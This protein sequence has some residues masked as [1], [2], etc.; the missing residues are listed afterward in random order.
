MHRQRTD[1]GLEGEIPWRDC[2]SPGGA[3][4]GRI[5]L[6]RP[7]ALVLGWAG[8]RPRVSPEKPQFCTESVQIVDT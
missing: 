4:Y 8:P 6:G 7:A 5:D 3:E 1:R 2:L